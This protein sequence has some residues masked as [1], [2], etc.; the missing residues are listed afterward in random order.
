MDVLNWFSFAFFNILDQRDS[1]GKWS[2]VI[3]L[4]KQLNYLTMYVQNCHQ[5]CR[6]KNKWQYIWYKISKW[7]CLQQFITILVSNL[8]SIRKFT[9]LWMILTKDSLW[10]NLFS[11][12]NT[13]CL[14]LRPEILT[15]RVNFETW[16]Q[17]LEVCII[18]HNKYQSIHSVLTNRDANLIYYLKYITPHM[19]VLNHIVVPLLAWYL[20]IRIGCGT[21]S[22]P[23]SVPCCRNFSISDSSVRPL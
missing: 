14:S 1:L 4:L 10:K 18:V 23:T 17:N 15:D 21:G 5:A 16:S 7:L 12:C 6:M 3:V 9:I 19:Y 8:N 13:S 20:R 11:F 22:R 2:P